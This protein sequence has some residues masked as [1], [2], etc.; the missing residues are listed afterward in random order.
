MVSGYATDD[1]SSVLFVLVNYSKTVTYPVKVK[2]IDNRA[3]RS[4]NLYTTSARAD[5]NLKLYVQEDPDGIISI[6]PR[7]VVTIEMVF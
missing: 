6:S 2:T 7:S 3:A 1:K 5:E 4:L